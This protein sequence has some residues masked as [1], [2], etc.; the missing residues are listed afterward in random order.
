MISEELKSKLESEM[1]ERVLF[2][3]P[4]SAHTTIKAGG[5]AD[6]FVTVSN[7]GELTDVLKFAKEAGLEVLILGAGSNLLMRDGGFDGIVVSMAGFK[8]FDVKGEMEHG[9][10]L[11]AGGGVPVGDL[12][13]FSVCEGLAGFEAL[14]GIPGTVGGALHMN[15]GTH[16]GSISDPLVHVVAMDKAG[17]SYTWPREKIEFSYRSAKFP[18][19]CAIIAAEFLLKK[20]SKEEIEK[21]VT[22]LKERRKERHPLKWPSMGSI[23]KNPAKGPSAGELIEDAGLKGVRVGGARVALEHGNW[24]INENSAKANDIE[25]LIHLIREK[26]KELMEVSLETEVIIVGRK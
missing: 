23:F 18:K 20:G 7:E 2:N 12:V 10:V 16:D 25:I 6:A 21:K 13:A 26:V 1:G 9:I 22:A 17:R 14:A 19:S 3:E 11:E 15:A 8:R 24:I 4:M 5:P